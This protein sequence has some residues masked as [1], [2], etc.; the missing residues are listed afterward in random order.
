MWAA[1]IGWTAWSLLSFWLCDRLTRS[2]RLSIF[3]PS[4]RLLLWLLVMFASFT[5]WSFSV[6]THG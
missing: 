4:I 3:R 2:I 6:V 1:I 5:V